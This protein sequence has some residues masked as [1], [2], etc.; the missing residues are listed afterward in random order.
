MTDVTKRVP[1]GA[2]GGAT[3][4]VVGSIT[5]STTVRVPE[6]VIGLGPFLL[7]EGDFSGALAFEDINDETDVDGYLKLQ[8]TW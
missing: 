7:L 4:R 5:E 2:A 3:L 8:G 1:S 6:D